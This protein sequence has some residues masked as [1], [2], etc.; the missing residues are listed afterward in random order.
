MR[1]LYRVV[2]FIPYTPLQHIGLQSCSTQKEQVTVL[3]L[4]KCVTSTIPVSACTA[5]CSS[6]HTG[7]KAYA[8]Q[9]AQFQCP[10]TSTCPLD[11]VLSFSPLACWKTL[12][13]KVSRR[14]YDFQDTGT[15]W[16]CTATTNIGAWGRCRLVNM[17]NLSGGILL[18]QKYHGRRC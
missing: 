3:I 5:T 15:A 10:C 4:Q 9:Y 2:W 16:Y 6:F 1:W 13:K 14:A 7:L 17:K 8:Y 12:W 18:P 11:L